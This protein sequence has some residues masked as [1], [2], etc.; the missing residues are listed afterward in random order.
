[1]QREEVTTKWCSPHG[2]DGA[3]V[4]CLRIRRNRDIHVLKA[5]NAK[6][7]CGESP[8]TLRQPVRNRHFGDCLHLQPV[9]DP[10]PGRVM[11]RPALQNLLGAGEDE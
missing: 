1:M 5:I 11:V 7:Y 3:A 8:D 10:I 4:G 6:E 9:C 2:D